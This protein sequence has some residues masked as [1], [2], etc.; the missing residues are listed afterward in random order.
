VIR[1]KGWYSIP[2]HSVWVRGRPA[3]LPAD[4][5]DDRGQFGEGGEESDAAW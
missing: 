2:T 3:P 5:G 1:P 4:H